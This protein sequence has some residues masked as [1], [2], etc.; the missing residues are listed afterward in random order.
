MHNK[1]YRTRLRV[2]RLAL[3]GIGEGGIRDHKCWKDGNSKRDIKPNEHF[4]QD[5]LEH[6]KKKGVYSATACESL[7][8]FGSVSSP[9]PKWPVRFRLISPPRA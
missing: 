4:K 7:R 5:R 8:C 2:T 9:V 1:I 3:F 6:W